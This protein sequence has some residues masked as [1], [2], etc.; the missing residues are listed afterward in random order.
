MSDIGPQESGVTNASGTHFGPAN[1]EHYDSSKWAMTTTHAAAHEIVLDPEPA[2]RQRENGEPASLKPSAAGPFLNSLLVILHSIPLAREALLSRE[3][4]LSDYGH[5]DEWW[6][7]TA[8]KVPR[9]VDMGTNGSAALE[10]RD[11]ILYETQRV[12]AFLD[13]TDRS[14]AS[15]EVLVNEASEQDQNVEMVASDYLTAWRQVAQIKNPPPRLCNVFQSTGLKVSS[16]TGEVIGRSLNSAIGLQLDDRFLGSDLSLYEAIDDLIWEG[17]AINEDSDTYLEDLADL[18][19]IAVTTLNG[20]RPRRG[21]HIPAVW[22]PDRYLEPSKHLARE[23]RAQ[24]AMVNEKIETMTRMESN[25]TSYQTSNGG[26]GVDPRHLLQTAIA[27]FENG[28]GSGDRPNDEMAS[29]PAAPNR[30]GEFTDKGSD[31]VE[32]LKATCESVTEKLDC[33]KRV[34]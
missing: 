24:K 13:G 26:N 34:V 1:R 30:T 31:I 9:I 2:D 15:V 7:G 6:K 33:K 12:L 27:H 8:I 19:T 25:L 22:Y 5:D 10:T 11:E 28:K 16:S 14:Y 4:L 21:I 17:N 20:N 23:M 29:S 3:H 32:R 18:F